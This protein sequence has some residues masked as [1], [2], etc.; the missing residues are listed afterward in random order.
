ME[1]N[2]GELDRLSDQHFILR[3]V[4]GTLSLAP[5]DFSTPNLRVLDSGTAGGNR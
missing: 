4:I 3:R 2:K 1:G 5:I